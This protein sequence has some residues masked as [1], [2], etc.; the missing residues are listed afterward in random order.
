[1][2]NRIVLIVI[3]SLFLAMAMVGLMVSSVFSQTWY[4]A[5]QKTVG[6]DAVTQLDDGSPIPPDQSIRYQIYIAL[7]TDTTKAN[8]VNIGNSIMTQF[9]VT[10]PAEGKY[11]IGM[12]AERL[13]STGAVISKSTT[14]SWSDDPASCSD[15][16][17]FGVIFF[18]ALKGVGGMKPL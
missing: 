12:E 4:P 3:A 16:T 14:I 17:T 18:R 10:F 11:F 15:G 13:D 9:V 2:K 6:W 8:K 5:N 7:S 1:M